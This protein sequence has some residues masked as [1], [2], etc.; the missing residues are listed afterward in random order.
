[1]C[2]TQPAAKPSSS[3][4]RAFARRSPTLVRSA[5]TSL[6]KT[7]SCTAAASRVLVSRR[8]SGR[9]SR[10]PSCSPWPES[11]SSSACPGRSCRR[12]RVVA[13]RCRAR[14][15]RPG[16]AGV[17]VVGAHGPCTRTAPSSSSALKSTRV[18]PF[19]NLTSI[20]TPDPCSTSD[21][22]TRVRV[23]R[24]DGERAAGAT[25]RHRSGVAGAER[26]RRAVGDGRGALVLARSRRAAPAPVPRRP[27][28]RRW[29]RSR[30]GSAWSSCSRRRRRVRRRHAHCRSRSRSTRTRRSR[31]RPRRRRGSGPAPRAGRRCAGG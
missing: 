2:G 15:C 19:T 28:S 25:D 17:A 21:D 13:R 7:P 26:R 8:W 18:V 29:R 14:S 27:A 4:R 22:P 9:S 30:S 1:M 16:R 6:M 24:H 11:R 23:H 5:V 12:S 3:A 20:S 31:T 10:G